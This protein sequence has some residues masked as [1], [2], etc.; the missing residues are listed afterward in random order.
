[1]FEEMLLH[2]DF[3]FL[4]VKELKS[5]QIYQSLV[6]NKVKIFAIQYNGAS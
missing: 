2:K 5:T 4:A 6:D 1:M 3:K